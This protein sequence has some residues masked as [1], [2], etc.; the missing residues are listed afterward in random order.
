[1]KLPVLTSTVI[2]ALASPTWA[3]SPQPPNPAG[4]NCHI[5]QV[6]E[7]SNA[8]KSYRQTS[9]QVLTSASVPDAVIFKGQKL[10]Y[11]VNGDFDS[12]SIHV[13]ALSDDS[14][15]A[16]VRGPITLDGEIIG[17]AVDPD[18]IVTDDG[19]LRLYYYVGMFTR[20]VRDPKPADFFSAISD[21]GI[22]FSVEGVV[23]TV[24]GGTAPTVVRKRDGS[25]LLAIP[26]GETMN[27]EIFESADGRGFRRIGS[28]RGG[29]PELSLAEDGTV[30]ILFQDREGIRKLVST[31]GGKSWT[32]AATNVLKGAAKGVASPSVIRLDEKRRTMFY[33]KARDGCST[34]PTA[35]LT[36]KNAL[37]PNA[38]HAGQAKGKPPLGDGVEP[39]APRPRKPGSAK[40]EPPLGQGVQPG[41]TPRN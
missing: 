38:G 17:D 22:N 39:G 30:E 19:R 21:D 1:M 28:L 10:I 26:Q 41:G 20:P 12:H 40:G 29:I 24:R 11:Y 6:A 2:L 32:K 3:S 36:D 34:P 9:D 18:L 33:F 14:R 5:V 13:A 25:Y 37:L 31:D 16:T 4:P 35:Y 23:A 8:G 7:S 15:T 27:I